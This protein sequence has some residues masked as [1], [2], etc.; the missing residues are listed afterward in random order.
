MLTSSLREYVW[1][2][3]DCIPSGAVE[4]SIIGGGALRSYWDG[5]PVK[6]I[7]LFFRSHAD[8][9]RALE[10]FHSDMRFFEVLSSDG[11]RDFVTALGERFSLIGFGFGE[12]EDQMLRFD[13]RC[14]AVVAWINDGSL[15]ILEDA[16]AARDAAL[17]LLYIRNQHGTNRTMRRI[18][19]YVED[20]GYELHPDQVAELEPE[21]PD[22][23]PETIPKYPKDEAPYK[24]LA[25]RTLLG[26]PITSG[27]YAE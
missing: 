18:E 24:A 25:R 15:F 11:T 20:Y 2:L 16:E 3:F 22:L 1:K 8:F 13:F 21:E 27:G 6:D 7:D 12:P 9:L 23:F 14:C 19:H 4:V 17:K 10:A 26:I 5:T